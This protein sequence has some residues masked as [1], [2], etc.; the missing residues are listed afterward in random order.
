MLSCIL[1]MPNFSR[2]HAG[3]TS[4]FFSP[5][6]QIIRFK[7]S[8]TQKLALF[9][10]TVLRMIHKLVQKKKLIVK[11]HQLAL[12]LCFWA[13]VSPLSF[14]PSNQSSP[15][16]IKPRLVFFFSFLSQICQMGCDLCWLWLIWKSYQCTFSHWEAE[17][18]SLS[19][20]FSVFDMQILVI[21]AGDGSRTILAFKCMHEECLP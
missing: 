15:D 16:K 6:L 1:H 4:L 14:Q 7:V 17:K 20:V 5:C 8:V 13:D 19:C 12:W 2:M 11:F 9:A 10:C 21:D 18:C 3:S